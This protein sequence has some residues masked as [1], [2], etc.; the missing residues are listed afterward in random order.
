MISAA[1]AVCLSCTLL[2]IFIWLAREVQAISHFLRPKDPIT[3]TVIL[4]CL[5]AAY[6]L[7]DIPPYWYIPPLIGYVVGYVLAGR[8]QPLY[9]QY[10]DPD[11]NRN[12]IDYY[13]LYELPNHDGCQYIADQDMI[14]FLRRLVGVHHELITDMP[15]TAKTEMTIHVPRKRKILHGDGIYINSHHIESEYVKVWWRITAKKQTTTLMLADGSGFD[16][17]DL[18][19]NFSIL[20]KQRKELTKAKARNYK[21]ESEVPDKIAMRITDFIFPA[22]TQLK[23]SDLEELRTPLEVIEDEE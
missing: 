9:V 10:V 21:L 14:S 12:W 18:V 8:D 13:V 2:V 5:L 4:G 19:R 3:I 23:Q 7:P 22:R 16:N 11:N 15:I 17:V 1:Y 6:Y 20:E